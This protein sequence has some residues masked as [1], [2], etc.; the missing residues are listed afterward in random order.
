MELLR[1]ADA[2][3]R[4][5]VAV[6]AGAGA[7]LRRVAAGTLAD[8]LARRLDD[9]R[10]LL[11]A[12]LAEGPELPG[13]ARL[14]PPVDGATEVWACGVTYVRSRQARTLESAVADVY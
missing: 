9:V 7:P 2:A 8:V 10:A 11:E 1:V 3:G 6:R 4:P 12:A 13:P 14:L 5:A